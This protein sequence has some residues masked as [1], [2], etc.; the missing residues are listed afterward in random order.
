M[1]YGKLAPYRRSFFG[2]DPRFVTGSLLLDL[3]RA[4]RRMMGKDSTEPH[5]TRLLPDD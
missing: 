3:H 5:K 1:S 4:A 2:R